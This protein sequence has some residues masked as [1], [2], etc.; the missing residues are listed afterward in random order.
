VTAASAVPA[1]IAEEKTVFESAP[2]A[3]RA[4]VT[5]ATAALQGAADASQSV[6]E[7]VPTQ[8]KADVTSKTPAD[9][10]ESEYE[11]DDEGA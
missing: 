1:T 5:A 10:E 3:S 2:Q 11:T 9:G 6:F 8:S 7:S 4:S